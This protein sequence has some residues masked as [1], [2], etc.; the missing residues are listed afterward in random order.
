ME[1]SYER[2]SGPP[3]DGP[4]RSNARFG[5]EVAVPR[6]GYVLPPH[7]AGGNQLD[8]DGPCNRARLVA[9]HVHL[10]ASDVDERVVRRTGRVHVRSAGR[11]VTVVRGDGALRDDH[12]ARPRMR[13]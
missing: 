3:R 8:G 1:R 12:E 7:R 13:M 9:N 4:L 11:V 2:K 5:L 6:I 10:A